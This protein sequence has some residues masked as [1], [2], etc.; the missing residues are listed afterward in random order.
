MSSTRVMTKMAVCVA[1]ICV[2]AY[3]SFP[4]PFTTVPL[5]FL[6][7]AMLLAAFLLTPVQTFIVMIVYVFIGAAGLPVF[8]GG[9]GGAGVLVSPN[10][11][12]LL[13]FVCAYPVTSLLKGAKP[14]LPRYFAAGLISLPISYL[15]GAA[16]LC[17]TAGLSPMQAVFAGVLPFIIG[18]LIKN[19]LAAY[20]G[21]RLRRVLPD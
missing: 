2:S 21:V 8:A 16:G 1:I 7:L 18:D 13:G 3:L 15:F 20:I 19:L 14:D 11:G 17:L 4:I 6:T 5:T 9:T 10:G 12:Y